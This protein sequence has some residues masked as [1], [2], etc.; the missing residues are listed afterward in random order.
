MEPVAV[1]VSFRAELPSNAAPNPALARALPDLAAWTAHFAAVEIPVMAETADALEAM[2]ANEDHVDANLIG[3]MVATDPLM[4][5][6][7]MA[8]AAGHRSARQLTDPET[9]TGALVMLGITPFFNAFGAQTSVEDRLQHL[10]AALAGL[11]R[12]LRRSHRAARFA[13]SFAAH[14]L[15]PDAAVVHQ[16]ALLHDLAELLLWCHAPALATALHVRQAADAA[17][18]SSDAQRQVLNIELQ[19]LQHALMQAWRLPDLLIRIT[20]DRHAEQA[21]VRCVMLGVRLA[22]HTACGWDNAALAD[23]VN[24]LAQLLT[25]SPDSVLHLLHAVDR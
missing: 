14:L 3:E 5:L 4:T 20:D 13:L 17:L 18:R 8:Y 15:D 19:D 10:P 6:K 25:L 24:D 9:V 23:D 21:A 16:A 12:V 22:R 1:P 7:V 2:R 11:R